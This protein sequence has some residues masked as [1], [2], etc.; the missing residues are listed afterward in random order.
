MPVIINFPD[1]SCGKDKSPQE[2]ATMVE[3]TLLV[4]LIALVLLVAVTTFGVK[5][6]A[7][8]SSIASAIPH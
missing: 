7:Q 1:K 8:Y 5:L 6:S 2:G 4:A 3:Y